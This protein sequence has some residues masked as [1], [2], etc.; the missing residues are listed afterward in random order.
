[1]CRF[2][3]NFDG[4]WYAQEM[5]WFVNIDDKLEDTTPRT[6]NFI[7]MVKVGQL[8]KVKETVRDCPDSCSWWR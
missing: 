5:Q 1:M 2:W 3:S 8:L 6:Y 4:A 7:R